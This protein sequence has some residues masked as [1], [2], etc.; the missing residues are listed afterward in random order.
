MASTDRPT[1]PCPPRTPLRETR[2]PLPTKQR[3]ARTYSPLKRHLNRT[4]NTS[5]KSYARRHPLST[6][7][8][9]RYNCRHEATK[10]GRP[11][12]TI[13]APAHAIDRTKSPTSD[14]IKSQ[15]KVTRTAITTLPSEPGW[16]SSPKTLP[17]NQDQRAKRQQRST[18]TATALPA[19]RY[20]RLQC[21][22]SI[23]RT[24]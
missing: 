3:G 17:T 2:L 15:P 23:V 16:S 12:E 19:N 4:P 5:V 13:T 20:S 9:R 8:L 18:D 14:L 1:I 24:I 22:N 7:P 21:L 11:I 6:R 10:L